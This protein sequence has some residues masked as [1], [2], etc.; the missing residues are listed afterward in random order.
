MDDGKLLGL[1][2]PLIAGIFALTFFTFWQRQK[3]Q[4]Y[5][6]AIGLAYAAMAV[7]FLLSHFL[8]GRM[9]VYNVVLSGTIYVFAATCIIDGL[10]NR[11]GL[12]S[13]A[14]LLATIGLSG[15]IVAV[16]ATFNYTALNM[17]I[18]AMNGT[19]GIIFL[20]GAWR[21]RHRA[22]ERGME[23]LII[24]V[25]AFIGLQFF[26][27]SM[28]SVKLS[29][30]I[31]HENY[32]QSL[33]WLTI[34]LLTALSSVVLA[35]TLIGMCSND[36]LKQITALANTDGQTG[37]YTRRAFE[38]MV[39]RTLARLD[40][41]PLPVALLVA[42]IDHFKTIN[43]RF[44]HPT[45]DAVIAALGQ[46]LAGRMRSSDVA[47]RLGGEEFSALLWNA[48][49][50]SAKQLSE[51]IRATFE[52]LAID[53]L[54]EGERITLS[55][56]FAIRGEGEGYD[57]LYRRADR[58]LYVAKRAGRNKVVGAAPELNISNDVAA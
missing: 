24:G 42:D 57:A 11:A 58:A 10:C 5:I 29:G 2:N 13:A 35:M 32:R 9:S 7:G 34:N 55:I 38:E 25:L 48:D 28:I 4:R 52:S 39:H 41:T 15:V 37:L 54:P 36:L 21:M 17:R 20:V 8:I 43:D 23:L 33:H 44:G 19:L 46:M 50:T 31:T 14:P 3:E 16:Y 22:S 18:I 1:L 45:G 40:R 12:R 47:G 26:L 6:F 49:E 27:A 30:V 53:E 51:E 56:G